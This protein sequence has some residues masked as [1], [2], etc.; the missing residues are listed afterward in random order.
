MEKMAWLE[1]AGSFWHQAR[2]SPGA[3]VFR[4]G[5]DDAGKRRQGLLA[6]SQT[7][8]GLALEIQGVPIGVRG[9]EAGQ[10]VQRCCGMPSSR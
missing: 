6:A 4:L 10:H 5:F 2:A 3:D 1:P 8:E 9:I 7:A